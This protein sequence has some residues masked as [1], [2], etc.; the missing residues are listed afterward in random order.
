MLKTSNFDPLE[1]DSEGEPKEGGYQGPDHTSQMI[2]QPRIVD[3]LLCGRLKKC[4]SSPNVRISSRLLGSERERSDQFNS[5]R[6]QMQLEKVHDELVAQI[7]TQL[8]TGAK[9][10]IQLTARSMQVEI[11][12]RSISREDRHSTQNGSEATDST[13]SSL[14]AT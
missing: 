12:S 7:V 3:G 11:G 8:R 6:A 2:T 9:R 14:N 1:I 4:L 13:H 5:Q 10:P